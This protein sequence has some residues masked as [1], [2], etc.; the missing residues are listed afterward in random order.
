MSD[1]LALRF[2]YRTVSGRAFL[3]LLVHPRV[4][5]MA[6][7]FLSLRLSAPLASYYIQKYGIDLSDI[8]V[9]DG[10]F[11]SF[12][13][14]FTRKRKTPCARP[15]K[16]EMISPC[17]GFLS[18]EAIRGDTVFAVKNTS[19][20]LKELL[21]ES[22]LAGRFRDGTAL[23]FRLT[24]ANYHRYVYAVSGHVLR[25]KRIDGVLHCVRPVALHTFPVFAQNSREYEVIQSPEFG[26]VVQ[27]EIGALLVGKIANHRRAPG[28]NFVCAGE[29]KGFFEFGGSTILA[30]LEK[31]AAHLCGPWIGRSGEN[32]EIPVKAGEL[33]GKSRKPSLECSEK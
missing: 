9:P 16:G 7:G 17:D 6:G 23:I 29:E 28:E 25:K 2:L 33:I 5:K 26:T 14:F 1:T 30:L 24:P 21:G 15:E 10:G 3:K 20:T 19:F 4:S 32:G 22:A 11:P 8:A 12:N 13:A 27:M 31:D 18:C